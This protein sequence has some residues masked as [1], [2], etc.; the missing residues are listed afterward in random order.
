MS[1][2]DR[3]PPED[4]FCDLVLTGGVTSGV[5]YPAAIHA[6]S[7]KYRF[8]AIGGTSAGAMAAA[9]TAAAEYARRFGSS[10]GFE[11]LKEIPERLARPVG[12][13]RDAKTKLLALF[14]PSPRCARLFEV[15][16]DVIGTDLQRTFDGLFKRSVKAIARVYGNGP[17]AI[18][19]GVFLSSLVAI[20]SGL[21]TTV[22]RASVAVLAFV[23]GIGVVIAVITARLLR[24]VR[25]GLIANDYGL[26]TGLSAS[27]TPDEDSEAVIDWLH[28][29]IQWACGRSTDDTPLTF[30][31]LWEAPATGLPPPK[32]RQAGRRAIDLRMVTTSLT[33]GRPYELPLADTAEN[34]CLFFCLDD[35][36]RYFPPRVI[37]QLR[38]TCTPYGALAGRFDHAPEPEGKVLLQMPRAR[39][40]LVVAARLSLS[41][42]VLFCA[43]PAWGFDPALRQFRPCWFSDG[44]ICANFPIHLFDAS[45]PSWP[46]FGV[47]LTE[48]RNGDDE[49]N[50]EVTHTHDAGAHDVWSDFGDPNEPPSLARLGRFA[51]SIVNTARRWHDHTLARMP[52]VRDRVVRVALGRDQG[53]LNLKMKPDD[54]L[55]MVDECGLKAAQELIAKFAPD[56]TQG[57]VATAWSE[58]RWVRFNAIVDG[59]R[60]RLDGLADAAEAAP[61]SLKISQQ[62]ERAGQHSPLRRGHADRLPR[63]PWQSA[64]PPM[65]EAEDETGSGSGDAAAR[66]AA[67]LGQHRRDTGEDRLDDDQRQA[68]AA[69]LDALVEF[70]QKL[71][72][73]WHE[74]PYVPNP[75]PRLAVRPPM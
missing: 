72:Q 44:G 39:M 9:L 11:V 3:E 60:E 32:P 65:F 2:D 27:D 61:Y 66:R 12:Q 18:V 53:E 45:I 14:Q 75:R 10:A 22:E 24:D 15:L 51:W 34:E 8:H 74:Q 6:L 4:R 25:D 30:K 70:E 67:P 29:G 40:P 68:L 17:A 73:S 69:L 57:S 5:I 7:R 35:W 33:H 26:C 62:I 16:L 31:D 55:R 48:N 20:A 28:K 38:A 49:S 37:E 43:V 23:I 42:P 58:H 50:V 59:L 46:T 54:I 64:P 19:T 41:F 1:A 52:G 71:Q 36:R 56:D 21:D 13:G 47:F 63:G